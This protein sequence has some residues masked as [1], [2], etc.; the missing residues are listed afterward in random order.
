MAPIVI[1]RSG[2]VDRALDQ[3]GVGVIEEVDEGQ[4]ACGA[5]C[6]R[7]QRWAAVSTCRNIT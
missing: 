7:R 2:V 4:L 5:H 3:R 1:A 6:S